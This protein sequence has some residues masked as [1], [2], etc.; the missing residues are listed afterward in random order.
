MPEEE[1]QERS[2]SS[3]SSSDSKA[4]AEEEKGDMFYPVLALIGLGAF[5]FYVTRSQAPASS[6]PKTSAFGGRVEST[7]IA[8]IDEQRLEG[9]LPP[10]RLRTGIRI[11]NKIQWSDETGATMA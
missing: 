8:H 1:K 2:D 5:F 3:S 6:S 4:A 10:S 7:N 11:G 9:K